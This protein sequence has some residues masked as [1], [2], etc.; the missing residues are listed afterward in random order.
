[1][2]NLS[3]VW[4]ESACVEWKGVGVDESGWFEWT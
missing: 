1:M 4:D 2:K 3:N